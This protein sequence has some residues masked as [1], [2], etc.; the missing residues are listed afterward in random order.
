VGA[1]LF[2][3]ELFKSNNS[4]LQN[5]SICFPSHTNSSMAQKP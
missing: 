2:F 1:K 3:N 5:L 4:A